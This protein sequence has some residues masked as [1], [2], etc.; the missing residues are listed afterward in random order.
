MGIRTGYRCFDVLRRLDGTRLF[1]S[2]PRDRQAY[3]ALPRKPI[4]VRK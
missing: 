4:V 3:K 2:A 1:Q